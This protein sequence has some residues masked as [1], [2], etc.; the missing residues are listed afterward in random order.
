MNLSTKDKWI[1]NGLEQFDQKQME[2]QSRFNNAF[3]NR[4][5]TRFSLDVFITGQETPMELEDVTME[6]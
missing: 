6:V 5:S 3:C 4:A 2:Q 1:K